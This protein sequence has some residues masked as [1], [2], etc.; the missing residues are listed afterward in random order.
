MLCFE[1]ERTLSLVVVVKFDW[2]QKLFR[3]SFAISQ[4][5]VYNFSRLFTTTSIIGG[6]IQIGGGGIL[7]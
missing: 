5:F 2:L 1:R 6:K 4:L 7:I 3:R